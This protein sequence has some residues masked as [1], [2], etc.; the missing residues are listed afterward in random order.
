MLTLTLTPSEALDLA[1]ALE[2]R[3]H[4][5]MDEL[6]HTDDRAYKAD[7]RTRYES[8]ERVHLQLASSLQFTGSS[9]RSE[10]SE[11]GERSEG[12]AADRSNRHA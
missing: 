6:V 12:S 9:E 2:I 1:N 10:R 5:M 11:R 8:L 3:L 7:V 4:E